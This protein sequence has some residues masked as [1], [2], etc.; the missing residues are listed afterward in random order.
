MPL[1]YTHS[2][3]LPLKENRQLRIKEFFIDGF[4]IFN[5]LHVQDVSP[6]FNIFLGDNEAGKSTL[7]A[8]FRAIFF[9]FETG[10]SRENPYKPLRGGIHGGIITVEMG[11]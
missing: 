3:R 9:G 10:Q 5:N 7:L 11:K 6:G 8:Y 1:R 4:G 2:M